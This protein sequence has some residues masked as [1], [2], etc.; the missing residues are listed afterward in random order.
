MRAA[1]FLCEGLM[2]MSGAGPFALTL[3]FAPCNLGSVPAGLFSFRFCLGAAAATRPLKHNSHS[4]VP[5]ADSFCRAII[6]T[7]IHRQEVLV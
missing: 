3:A 5:D 1:F 6:Y 4:S 2:G 7:G